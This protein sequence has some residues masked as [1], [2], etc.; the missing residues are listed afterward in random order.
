MLGFAE[1]I[2]DVLK[3]TFEAS[4]ESN[5]ISGGVKRDTPE[6]DSDDEDMLPSLKKAK[7]VSTEVIEEQ[8]EPV[9]V[10]KSRSGQKD[11]AR[12]F[13]ASETNEESEN[14]DSSDEEESTPKLPNIAKAS[15]ADSAEEIETSKRLDML[16]NKQHR[17]LVS[18][19][20]G[21]LATTKDKLSGKQHRDCLEILTILNEKHVNATSRKQAN[22]LKRMRP[23][24]GKSLFGRLKGDEEVRHPWAVPSPGPER[25]KYREERPKMLF[26]VTDQSSKGQI[27]DPRV[28]F[29]SADSDAFLNTAAKRK[30]AL[31]QHANFSNRRRTS[32]VS[33]SDSAVH[34]AKRCVPWLQFRQ[35]RNRFL[36]NTKLSII[37]VPA[38]IANGLPILRIQDELAHYGAYNA[39][40]PIYNTEWVC[41]FTIGPSEIVNTWA[42]SRVEEWMTQHKTDFAGWVE[43]VGMPAFEEHERVRKGGKPLEHAAGCKCC[44]H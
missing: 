32:F 39:A 20:R 34:I 6:E 8:T 43:K 14:E 18:S 38:R 42:W 17:G 11:E 16:R 22:R 40:N 9:N 24:T 13:M 33:F 12:N 37:S 21:I 25:E 28:G 15:I 44:G 2:T 36:D 27:R 19:L 30:T 41:P 26:R 3:A 7:L 1:T 23:T 5:A 4:E 29:I 10:H 35:A 31:Q